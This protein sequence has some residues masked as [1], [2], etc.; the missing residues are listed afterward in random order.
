MSS[1]IF[2]HKKLAGEFKTITAMIAIFCE[3]RHGSARGLLCPDCREL[4]DYAEKRLLLCPFQEEKPTCGNCSIHCYKRDMREK[5]KAVMRY[6]GPRMS[7]RHP[8]MALRH[9]LDSRRRAPAGKN[10]SD[11]S[12]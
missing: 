9:L 4:R 7:Y 2:G 8:V 11:R 10:Q 1:R 3:G 5:I 6:A 12:L